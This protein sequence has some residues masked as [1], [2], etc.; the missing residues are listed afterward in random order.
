VNRL[1]YPSTLLAL[2]LALFAFGVV[3]ATPAWMRWVMLGSG[4]VMLLGAFIRHVLGGI[5]AR[6]P[7]GR[8]KAELEVEFEQLQGRTELSFENLLRRQAELEGTLTDTRA[9]VPVAE[10]QAKFWA[11]AELASVYENVWVQFERIITAA[12]QAVQAR[13]LIP[14]VEE[15]Q[16][17]C[18]DYTEK[19]QLPLPPID[20]R[21]PGWLQ[22]LEKFNDN[23]GHQLQQLKIKL[24][25][26]V[27]VRY[28]GSPS[29]GWMTWE[30][31]RPDAGV[32]MEGETKEEALQ[33]AAFDRAHA[34]I[35]AT[36]ES[37]A[38]A[39]NALLH[40]SDF[41]SVVAQIELPTRPDPR[42]KLETEGL[43]IVG[44]A[45]QGGRSA[46]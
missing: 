37:L 21:P 43:T 13:A 29:G 28:F 19:N 46:D 35:S 23:Y 15:L 39:R 2:G 8:S 7:D 25:Q 14:E 6:T 24:S 27:D 41:V 26:F 33:R 5:G 30:R 12:D 31:A 34:Q 1:F 10:D 22:P 45:A 3:L 16:R 17:I 36:A 9:T 18:A 38:L 20:A 32:P 11:A 44:T 4:S 42:S 40:L